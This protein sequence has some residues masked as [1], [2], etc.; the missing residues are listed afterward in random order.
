MKWYSGPGEEF[1]VHK[2]Y[3]SS[4]SRCWKAGWTESECAIW[5]YYR[6]SCKLEFILLVGGP[7]PN[8]VV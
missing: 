6:R 1:A 8:E 2:T 3:W 7:D 5:T 4:S